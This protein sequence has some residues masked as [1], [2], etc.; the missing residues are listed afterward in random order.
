MMHACVCA[1]VRAC[2]CVHVC[3][4]VCLQLRRLE[5]N[6]GQL[7]FYNRPDTNS[8][9]LSDYH[10]APVGDVE[11]TKSVLSL[12]LGAIGSVKKVR[13]LYMVGQTRIHLDTV[14][15]LGEFVEFEVCLGIIIGKLF[16]NEIYV[17][18]GLSLPC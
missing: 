11:G 13:T 1:C 8:P 18:P 9:K 15:G 10:I 14:E 6:T 7:I 17:F 2:V 5:A 3:V 4:C 12:A 16:F